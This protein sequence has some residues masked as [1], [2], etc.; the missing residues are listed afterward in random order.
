[1]NALRFYSGERFSLP[2]SKSWNGT[3]DECPALQWRNVF[4]SRV[5]K[6]VEW[7]KDE[8]LALQWRKVFP[9]RV[10]KIVEWNKDEY[11]A[12]QW[13]NVFPARVPKNRGMRQMRCR[14]LH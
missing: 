12:L 11:L 6:I 8:C 5:P 2:C 14:A 13:R 3:K 1:M 7:N 10:P 4:P 9:S